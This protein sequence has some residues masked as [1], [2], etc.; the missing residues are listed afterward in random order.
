[1]QFERSRRTST[2]QDESKA[3]N[4]DQVNC[5]AMKNI[6]KPFYKYIKQHDCFGNKRTFIKRG[7]N[8]LCQI[9]AKEKKISMVILL[10]AFQAG[11][12]LHKATH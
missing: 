5:A 1:L 12:T 6:Y 9:I 8:P 7:K 3:P 4:T 10:Q 2:S 11:R